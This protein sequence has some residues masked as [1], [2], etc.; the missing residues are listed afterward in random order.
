[1][2]LSLIMYESSLVLIYAYLPEICHTNRARSRLSASTLQYSNICQVVIVLILS[3]MLSLEERHTQLIEGGAFERAIDS[4]LWEFRSNLTGF[5]VA[6]PALGDNS[7]LAA[8]PLRSPAASGEFGTCADDGAPCA[9]SKRV[10]A[11]SDAYQGTG[12]LHVFANGGGEDGDSNAAPMS[13]FQ[14]FNLPQSESPRQLMFSARVRHMSSGSS[15]AQFRIW[16]EADSDGA[17]PLVHLYEKS[18]D[19]SYSYLRQD[20]TVEGGVRQ[21][22][23]EIVFVGNGSFAVDDIDARLRVY[24][25]VPI[26]L[27]FTSIWWFILSN[28]AI[29]QLHQRQPLRVVPPGHNTIS[30]CLKQ[31]ALTFRSVSTAP[32]M[33]AFLW[34]TTFYSVGAATTISVISGY[35]YT[36]LEMSSTFI[37]LTLVAAQLCG[38]IGA[39]IAHRIGRKTGF[40]RALAYMYLLWFISVSLASLILH[41]SSSKHWLFLITPLMGISLGGSISL[42]R[43]VFAGMVLTGRLDGFM[44]QHVFISC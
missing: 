10:S 43:A 44:P 22:V 39:F 26:S 42:N 16:V 23:F 1:M 13:I 18:L 32:N 12:W 19:S 21:I 4:S 15:R 20:I 31:L 37:G 36:R 34:A 41:S 24:S 35:L 28:I 30:T 38:A 14:R 11:F 5:D 29:N 9:L 17:S 6:S 2:I 27:A 7:S 33:M 3:M 8:V 40:S 25:L